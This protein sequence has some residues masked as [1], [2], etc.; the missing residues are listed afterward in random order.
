VT[1]AQ[2]MTSL[3]FRLPDRWLLRMAGGTPTVV[4]GRVLE[5]ALEVLTARGRKGP[6]P[7]SLTPEQAR[8]GA[9]QGFALLAGP[10]RPGVTTRAITLPGPVTP[11]PARVHTPAGLPAGAPLVLYFHQGGFVVGNL[12]WCQAFCTRLADAARCIVASVDYRLAPE[13]PFPAPHED[14]WAAWEWALREAQAL[15]A[16]RDRIAV[17]GDS[18]GGNLAAYLALDA[19]RRGG[20]MP[21]FQLLIYPWVAAMTETESYTHFGDAWPLDRALMDW[22]TSLAFVKPE[23]REDWRVNLLHQDDL[24]TLPPAHIVNAGFDPLCDEGRLYAEKL[25]AAG[26]A[27]THRCYDSLAHS[28]TAMGAIPAAARAQAEIAAE[29]ARALD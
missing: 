15:G 18:A 17:A 27:A 28:F 24:G 3:M 23:D 5:P 9:N 11:I 10:D 8:R 21:A 2:Q 1:L 6:E 26:V 29:L 25:Q 16:N 13:H 4:Q 7:S 20:P 14:A 22:F 19:A 12:D